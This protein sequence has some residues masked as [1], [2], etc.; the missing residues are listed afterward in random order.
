M[1]F[2]SSFLDNN[3]WDIINDKQKQV[4]TNMAA[5]CQI[6]E[7]F[8]SQLEHKS[9]YDTK[10]F[11]YTCKTFFINFLLKGFMTNFICEIL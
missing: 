2:V 10:I 9:S 7:C 8:P 6:S 3:N 5:P 4:T 11:Y 1:H